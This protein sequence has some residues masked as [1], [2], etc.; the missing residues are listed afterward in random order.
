MAPGGALLAAL[1]Q[2][3]RF[4]L[5]LLQRQRGFALVTLV[6]LGIG[7]GVM[8]TV[9]SVA[10]GL[11]LRPPPVREPATLVRVFTGRY[12]GTPLLDL[13]AYDEAAATLDIAA[14]RESRVSVRVGNDA[15]RPLLASFVTGNY[16]DV[17]GVVATRGRTFLSHEGRTPGTSPVAVLSH[18]SWQRHFG[19]H[20]SAV[21]RAIVVNG[22]AFTVVGVMPEA[23]IGVMG[24]VAADIWIPV[25]MH[26]LLMP[27]AR[28]FT[29]R[30]AFYAQAVARLSAGVSLARAQAEA[31][32]RFVPWRDDQAK[33]ASE[34]GGL[35]LHPLHYLVP[36]LWNRAAL[37]L[38]I[39]A[40]LATSLLGITCLNLASLMVASNS[41]RTR[42]FAV[43]MAI[44]AGRGRL[45]WQ[46]SIEAFC[47]AC[48]GAV[49][50][51]GVAVLLTRI[52]GRWTPPV[53]VPLVLDVSPDWRVLV[54]AGI[55]TTLVTIAFGLL[56]AWTATRRATAFSLNGNS[57]RSTGAGRTR[58]RAT[59]LIAQLSLSMLL[60][61]VAGL[62]TRSLQHAERM[63]LGFEPD[64]VLMAALDLDVNGYEAQRGRQFYADLLDRVRAMPGVRH[65]SLLDVVPLTGAN[66]GS[67]MLAD[68]V[69]PP[70]AGRTDGLVSVGR[71]SVAGGHFATLRIGMLSGRDFSRADDASAPAVAIVNET[72]A[73]TFWPGESPIGRRLR[74]HEP[75]GAP[76]PPIEVV[77][78]VRDSRYVSVGEQPRPF[79]YRPVAQ[80][81]RSD[82]ALI[83]R[84]D[85]P[86]L[87]FAPQ[88]RAAIRGLDPDLPIVDLRTLTEATSLSLLPIRVAATVVAA[89]AATVLGLAA[90]GFYGVLSFLVGQR[91]REIGIY[92]ALGADGARVGRM[93]LLEALRWI[94][95]G[96]AAGLAMAWLVAP[97]ASSLLYGV[98]PRDPATL[99]AV[100]GVLL[101]VGIA[102]ALLP[103]WR[104]STLSPA[105]ALRRD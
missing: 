41:A 63:D 9:V 21:G 22:H 18:R 15:A 33:D 79:M 65:A 69:P 17:L 85:G 94:G 28:T 60:L 26:P 40:G 90:L 51:V 71:K 16:F 67:Q 101:A 8:T 19:G 98:A 24:P 55:V 25:T 12:S 82:A 35:H 76:S 62:L 64:G 96:V 39:L 42:E 50:G 68:G 100:T 38:A 93:I 44:G 36:E 56:P 89:L 57:I 30:D 70:A 4:T 45:L 75:S 54:A 2:D 78:L 58:T 27:G 5:R 105:D 86:P 6:V 104:A 81:Y 1:I 91:T 32:A 29:D 47:L 49:L 53:D 52:I 74:F 102:S 66:R 61:T 99:A 43:R 23:F 46:L 92:M 59:L 97:L 11:L 103:A 3:L 83:V 80:E 7:T 84:V 34:P 31:D 88:L 95:W 10:N 20:D 37:F 48:G 73:R 14:F 87:A 72:L 13:L 77:G